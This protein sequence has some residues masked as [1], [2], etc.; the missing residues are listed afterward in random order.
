MKLTTPY[1]IAGG[2]VLAALAW[3]AT[4]GAQGTGQAIGGAAVDLVDGVVSGA[5]IGAG[6]LVGIPATSQTQCEIDRANGDTWAASFSCPAKTFLNYV[7][8]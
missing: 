1:L 7:F 6:E 3:A 2:A 8:N 5:V 4:R